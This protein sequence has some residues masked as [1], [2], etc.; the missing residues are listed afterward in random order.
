MGKTTRKRGFL[1]GSL[2]MS[3]SQRASALQERHLPEVVQRSGN[4]SRLACQR[5]GDSSRLVQE[6]VPHN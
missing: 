2:Y 1:Q 3:E 4:S 6:V 5:V